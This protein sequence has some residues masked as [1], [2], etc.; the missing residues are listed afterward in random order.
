MLKFHHRFPKRGAQGLTLRVDCYSY[1]FTFSPSA[2]A[3]AA[4]YLGLTDKE[5][6][7]DV[8][9]ALMSV[10]DKKSQFITVP[11]CNKKPW[12]NHRITF[13]RRG[14]FRDHVEIRLESDA[15]NVALVTFSEFEAILNSF[16]EFFH[17][18]LRHESNHVLT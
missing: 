11:L 8:F 15:E 7:K 4:L 5:L 14:D 12:F 16:S 17:H 6:I 9:D 13:K 18:V 1:A 3:P 2:K 10:Y